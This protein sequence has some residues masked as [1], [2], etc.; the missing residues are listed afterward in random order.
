MYTSHDKMAIN[1]PQCSLN[2]ENNAYPYRQPRRRNK[3]FLEHH[4]SNGLSLLYNPLS[5]FNFLEC[6]R[7]SLVHR[8][9]RN[10]E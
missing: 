5:L 7:D 9:T 10:A 8:N 6:T 2:N 3:L 4:E 1:M